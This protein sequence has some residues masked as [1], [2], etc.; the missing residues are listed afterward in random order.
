MDVGEEDIA[1]RPHD[2]HVVLNVQ[3]HL[4]IVA[5]VSASMAVV[6]QDWVVEE[7]AQAIEIGAQTV[8]HD[9]VRGDQE[10]IA[11]QVGVGS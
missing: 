2:A 11:G 4:E 9:D 10:E 8:E 1:R 7:D 5:P 6:G 3:R